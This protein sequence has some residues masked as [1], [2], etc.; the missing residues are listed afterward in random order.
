MKIDKELRNRFVSDYNLPI[1][2][3]QSPY[4]EERLELFNDDFNS[5]DKWNWVNELI[6]NKFDGNYSDFLR[7][8]SEVRNKIIT[9]T[10]NSKAYIEFNNDKTLNDRFNLTNEYSNRNLYTCEQ[11]NDNDLFLAIDLS[12]ANFQ[13]LKFYNREIVLNCDSYADFI[14][15]FTDLD[16]IKESKY[17][18]QVIFGKMNPKRIIHIEKY[19]MQRIIE[20]DCIKNNISPYF[21]IFSVNCDEVIFKLKDGF[22]KEYESLNKEFLNTIIKDCIKNTI[23]IDVKISKFKLKLH[24]F[25]LHYSEAN[26]FVF[27]K[28]NLLGGKNNIMCCPSVYAPQVY[29]LLKNKEVTENDLVFYH[30]NEL[31]KFLKPITYVKDN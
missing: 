10:I 8:Y 2:V 15:N 27:E 31:C 26:L 29:K 19:I 7:E 16:Y 13:A 17:T 30:N 14:S 23:G 11:V 6:V 9:D 24:H 4:F 5:L 25:K 20:S 1:Q 28:I 21:D 3:I 12:K 22:I 18:R